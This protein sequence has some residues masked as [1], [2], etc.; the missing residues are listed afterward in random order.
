MP[1]SQ[2]LQALQEYDESVPKMDELKF[3]R[4]LQK[5]YEQSETAVIRRIREVRSLKK[6]GYC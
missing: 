1:Y 3:V 6:Y 4:G 2:I 5:R